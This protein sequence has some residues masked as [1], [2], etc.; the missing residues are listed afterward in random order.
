MELTEREKALENAIEQLEKRFGKGTIMRLRGGE[1]IPV[2]AIPTGSLSLDKALGI[3]GVPRGRIVEVYGQESSGKTTLCLHIISEAQRRGG[4]AAFIDAENALDPTY[5]QRIGVD[6]ESLLISQPDSG[7]QALEIVETLVRSNAVDVIVVDSVAALTPKAEIEGDMG[8]S[9]VGLQ[10]RLMSQ[11]L[12]K[13]TSVVNKT[14]TCLIFTNQLR[15]KIGVTYGNPEVTPGGRALKFYA[16]VR[17]EM[18]AGESLK[19]GPDLIGKKIRVKVTK[20]KVAPPFTE[21]EFEMIFG[22]GISRE[23]DILDTGVEMGII[24]RSGA[25]YSYG[26]HKLGQGR[27][28]V[29]EFFRE[30][31]QI[32]AEIEGKIREMINAQKGTGEMPEETTAEEETIEEAAN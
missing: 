6:L 14:K 1:V 29:K 19:S 31:P 25:W 20:N 15:E 4:I 8:D 21:A 26:E 17:I 10:A 28:K 27:D 24:Q 7:E 32:A 30:N 5:A 13:L 11:A 9:H 2:E 18:R 23:G 16:S 12:R 22:E 3:G